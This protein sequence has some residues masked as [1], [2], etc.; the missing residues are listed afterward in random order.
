MGIFSIILGFLTFFGFT[1]CGSVLA[2]AIKDAK[3]GLTGSIVSLGT[4]S[5]TS[6]VAVIIAVFAFIGLLVGMRLIMNGATYRRTFY[7]RESISAR[8]SLGTI[9]ILLGVIALCLFA[10]VGMTLA[11]SVLQ[12][13][14]LLSMVPAFAFLN[15][16]SDTSVYWAVIGFFSLIG[17]LI[18]INLTMHG[19]VHNRVTRMQ[20]QLRRRGS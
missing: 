9:S 1:A 13:K 5:N 4:V 19:L 14:P 12:V 15:N 20:T 16:A 17:L 18:C 2:I 8:S 6:L 3:E 10:W 7:K 11:G